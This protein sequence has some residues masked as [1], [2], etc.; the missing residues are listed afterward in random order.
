MN[1]SICINEFRINSF[2]GKLC[3]F[4]VAFGYLK[5]PNKI[6]SVQLLVKRGRGIG[7]NK[8]LSLGWSA[9]LRE[10]TFSLRKW[11]WEI[12]LLIEPKRNHRGAITT[13]II[14][15]ANRKTFL[16]SNARGLKSKI[17]GQLVRRIILLLPLWLYVLD[18]EVKD[19]NSVTCKEDKKVQISLAG[20]S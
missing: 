18:R 16:E 3:I 9:L 6:C 4:L 19:Y 14:S 13:T 7:L 8:S 2:A 17:L 20:T 5:F 12:Y 11:F 10:S 1:A 15:E